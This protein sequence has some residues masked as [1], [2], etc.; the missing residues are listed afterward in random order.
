ME[1]KK[2]TCPNCGATIYESEARCPFCGY[3]NVPGAEEKFMRDIKKT[4]HDMV[5]ILEQQKAEYRNMMSSNTKDILTLMGIGVIVAAVIIGICKFFWG[6]I[7]FDTK[8]FHAELDW[9]EEYIPVLDKLYEQGDFD[10]IVEFSEEMYEKHGIF[11]HSW[12]GWE[13]YRFINNYIEYIAVERYIAQLDAGEELTEYEK[14]ELAYYCI[15]FY[16]REYYDEDSSYY[17][18]DEDIEILDGYREITNKYMFGRL[19]FSQEEA[20][21]L[22]TEARNKYNYLSRSVISKYTDK[23]GDRFQ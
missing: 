8:E 18:S 10:R 3:I 21:K 22:V 5:H 12:A 2:V 1:V 7:A 14:G 19:G 11:F 23:V 4:E 20:D 16:N 13:H 17:Y 6:S 15:C 9:C